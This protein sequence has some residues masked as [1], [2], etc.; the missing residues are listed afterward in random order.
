MQVWLWRH[1]RYTAG[2]SSRQFFLQLV[3]V[4]FHQCD[5]SGYFFGTTFEVYPTELI[6]LRL[7]MVYFVLPVGQLFQQGAVQRFLFGKVLFQLKDII[8]FLGTANRR[9]Q[10][11]SPAVPV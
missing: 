3:Q 5:T 10:E 1:E 6:Q 4:G 7:L 11:A 8:S 2:P 9:H